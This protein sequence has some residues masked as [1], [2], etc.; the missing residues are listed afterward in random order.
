M[1]ETQTVVFDG[2]VSAADREEQFPHDCSF[3]ES[4]TSS[5][6]LNYDSLYFALSPVTSEISL[7]AFHNV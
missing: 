6:S 4:N 2:F 3:S 1:N 5:S 7:F